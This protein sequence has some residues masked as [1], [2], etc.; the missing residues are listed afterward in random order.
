MDNTKLVSNMANFASFFNDGERW[1]RILYCDDEQS[2]FYCTDEEGCEYQVNYNEVD[3][4]TEKF[5]KSVEMDPKDY[6]NV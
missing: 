3:L 1:F 4:T 6:E 2:F 5:Y